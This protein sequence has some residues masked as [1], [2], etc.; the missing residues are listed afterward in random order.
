MSTHWPGVFTTENNPI[1]DAFMQYIKANAPDPLTHK[2]YFD[3]GTETLDAWYGKYQQ[4]ADEIFR[5]KG[6]NATNYKSMEFNGADH[7]EKSWSDRMDIP[8]KFL[9]GKD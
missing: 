9:L 3:R 7:S 6:Y 4:Q 1:P 2:L 8:L 5:M